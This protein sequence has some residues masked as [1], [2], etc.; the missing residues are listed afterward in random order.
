MISPAPPPRA[1]TRLRLDDGD[2]RASVLVPNSVLSA[3]YFCR[4]LPGQFSQAPKRFAIDFD[5]DHG[6]KK[7]PAW[8]V[9]R[10]EKLGFRGHADVYMGVFWNNKRRRVEAT[11]LNCTVSLGS[12]Q[13]D[14]PLWV[15]LSG[16]TLYF[17]PGAGLTDADVAGQLR[18]M[19]NVTFPGVWCT[20]AGGAMSIRSRAP[21]YVFSISTSTNLSVV[22]GAPNL[23]TLGAEGDW[24]MI[25]TISPVMTQGAR[26]WIRD[27]A[28]QLQQAGIP[29]SFAFSMECY[30]PPAAMAARYWD[31]APVD[32]P[33]PSTQMH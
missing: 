16:T 12:W 4:A 11:Y 19:L 13:A 32:L 6:Y 29:A 3:G 1:G 31:G 7:P 33:V 25:D 23:S 18:A 28:T 26:N 30:R 14:E 15:N 17:S 22:Q 21:G 27:L 5:T 24:E 2:D 20:S 9:W 8:H 10:R